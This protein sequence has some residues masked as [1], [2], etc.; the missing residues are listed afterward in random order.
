MTDLFFD[1][2]ATL[3]VVPLAGFDMFG[4]PLGYAE[5][6]DIGPCSIVDSHGQVQQSEDGHARWVGTVDVQAPPDTKLKVTDKIRLP[7]GTIGVVT[8]PPEK[9]VNPF[10]GWAPFVRF[11]MASPGYTPA[12][13]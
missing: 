4:D 9:P 7:N 8:Q 1:A 13:E 6:Y 10:T 12:R 2:G 5:E 11:T 3:T